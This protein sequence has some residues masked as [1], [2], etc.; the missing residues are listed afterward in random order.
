MNREAS[1]HEAL[2]HKIRGEGEDG[3]GKVK[4]RTL[5]TA[6]DA[7][8]G[9]RQEPHPLSRKEIAFQEHVRTYIF[10]INEEEAR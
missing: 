2:E 4:N 10:G 5:L 1:H 3:R 7:A 9:K 8:P 6:E